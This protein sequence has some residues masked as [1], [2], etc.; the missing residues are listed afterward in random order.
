MY[1]LTEL[2]TIQCRKLSLHI[3]WDLILRIRLY[4]KTLIPMLTQ[5]PYSAKTP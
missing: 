3:L 4:Q 5:K 1:R 2:V